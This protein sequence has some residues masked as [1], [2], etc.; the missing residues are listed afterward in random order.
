MWD[1]DSHVSCSHIC[2]YVRK[3]LIDWQPCSMALHLAACPLCCNSDTSTRMSWHSSAL[4]WAYHLCPLCPASR[5][6]WDPHDADADLGSVQVTDVWGGL[7]EGYSLQEVP[8]ELSKARPWGRGVSIAWRRITHTS[9]PPAPLNPTNNNCPEE[10]P[11]LGKRRP[12]ETIRTQKQDGQ[13]PVAFP[14]APSAC[15]CVCV[16]VCVLT[17]GGGGIHEMNCSR[18]D[19]LH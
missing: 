9:A 10:W 8:T 15:M 18:G 14:I 6:R 3:W 7:G 19:H 5:N 12:A 2:C 13:G 4:M 11:L 16:R 1:A 17:E